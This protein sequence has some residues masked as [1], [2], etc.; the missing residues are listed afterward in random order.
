MFMSN[1][2]P[3]F[4]GSWHADH[5]FFGSTNLRTTPGTQSWLFGLMSF[6]AGS[7]HLTPIISAIRNI[8]MD[9]TPI[10]S[11]IISC[12][13][14]PIS[15]LYSSKDVQRSAAGHL[16][17]RA[18]APSRR[19]GM[20]NSVEKPMAC[21]EQRHS[22]THIE[23]NKKIPKHDEQCN[24]N[25]VINKSCFGANCSFLGWPILVCCHQL[26]C[27]HLSILIATFEA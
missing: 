10:I 2:N 21:K 8:I 15:I 25:A 9:L 26:L 23:K 18:T 13:L 24:S 17:A 1:S 27:N 19:L 5:L 20:A 11:A 16:Q 14:R 7:C 6:L 4:C 3:I 22:E 12:Y